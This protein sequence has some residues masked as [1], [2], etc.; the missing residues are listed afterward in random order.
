MTSSTGTR[1]VKFGPTSG[2]LVS[3]GRSLTFSPDIRYNDA[4]V[5]R[6]RNL[7]MSNPI[8]RI[9]NGLI[10]VEKYPFFGMKYE[11]ERPNSCAYTDV[12]TMQRMNN[13]L[14]CFI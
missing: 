7:L 8:P 5:S 2:S 1:M 4:P 11:K 9:E 3:N 12:L 10:G 14:M 6:A 13:T